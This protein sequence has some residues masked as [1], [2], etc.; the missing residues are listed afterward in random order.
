MTKNEKIVHVSRQLE[1]LDREG[2]AYI[3]ALTASLAGL[4]A[5]NIPNDT[6]RNK[7]SRKAQVACKSL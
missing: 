3:K 5:P 7:T 6:A 4:P 2:K 1:R